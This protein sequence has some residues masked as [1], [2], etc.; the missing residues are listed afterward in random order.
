MTPF[1]QKS[2]NIYDFLPIQEDIPQ[3]FFQ[4][5]NNKYCAI[6]TKWFFHGL[7]K[8]EEEELTPVKGI[9][10]DQALT[11]IWTILESFEPSHECKIA[12]CAYLLKLWFELKE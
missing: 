2:Y 8:K 4:R 1:T 9:D 12:S 10:R 7:S 6:V 3:E 11:H 5:H